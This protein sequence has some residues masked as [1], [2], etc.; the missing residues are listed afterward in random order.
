MSESIPLVDLQNGV[1]AV[2]K[3]MPAGDPHISRLKELGLL[4][5]TSISVVRRHVLGDPLEIATRSGH[6]SISKEDAQK[7]IVAK[8]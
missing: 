8:D 4:P 6:L 3:S 1:T 5:N 2:V 7:I